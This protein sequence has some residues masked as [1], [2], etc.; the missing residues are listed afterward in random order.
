MTPYDPGAMPAIER[1]NDDGTAA[2]VM[3]TGVPEVELAACHTQVHGLVIDTRHFG[4][5][6]PE[7]SLGLA[8]PGLCCAVILG[9]RTCHDRGPA[10]PLEHALEVATCATERTHMPAISIGQR[11]TS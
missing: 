3:R 10:M 5:H 7:L 8:L 6:R 4:D 11:N 1:N 9:S 2:V